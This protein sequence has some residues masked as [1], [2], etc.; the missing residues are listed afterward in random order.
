LSRFISFLHLL[1]IAAANPLAVVRSVRSWQL[2]NVILFLFRN[3]GNI[4]N[5]LRRA[6]QL[7]HFR[8][9]GNDDLWGEVTQYLLSFY[10]LPGT[11]N[12]D[13]SE[14]PTDEEIERWMTGLQ[15][16]TKASRAEKSVPKI[17]IIIPV[18]NQIRFTLACLHSVFVHTDRDDYEVI[19]ADD[20][21]TD[22]TFKVFQQ[23]ISRVVCLRNERGLGFLR[24]CNFAAEK[25]RGQYLV[26]LNNDTIV[27]PG[28]LDE[29]IT[30]LEGDPS[31]GLV[32]SKLLLPDKLL[33]EAGGIVF[34][35]GGAWN[36]GAFCD[37]GAPQFSYLRDVDYCSGASLAISVS[38]W[39]RLG[40]FDERFAP[41]YYEDTD[42]AFQVRASGKRVVYQPFSRLIHFGGVSNGKSPESGIKKF[43]KINQDKFYSKWRNALE[44]HGA[45]HPESL[46]ADRSDRGRVLFIDALIT[47]PDSDS[48]SMDA[49]NYMKIMK[50]LGFHVTFVPLDI[51]HYEKYNKILQRA[52]IES[53]YLP[54]V[55]SAKQAIKIYGPGSDIIILCRISVASSLLDYARRHAPQAKIIFDTV[56]LHFLR[57][58]REKELLGGS[59][60]ARAAGDTR[61]RE[62]RAI[63]KSDATLLRSTY[64]IELVRG[65]VPEAQLFHF[66]IVRD[67][68]GVSDILWEERRDIVFIGGFI[69]P[70]NIDAVKYFVSEV[71]PLL[72]AT[73]FQGRFVIIG[74]NVPEEIKAMAADDIVIRGFVEDLS[75]IFNRC[76]L[77]VAPIRYGAG[78]KGKVITSLSYGVPCVATPAAVEGSGLVHDE[79]VVVA[80]NAEEMAEMIQRLYGDQHLWNRL[81]QAGLAFCE[82]HFSLRV[83]RNIIDRALTDVLKKGHDDNVSFM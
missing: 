39:R 55:T 35:D 54:W 32:G 52:G 53:L 50:E 76:R 26:F 38:L 36:Y 83:A 12:E 5:I 69:H 13:V 11:F 72:R 61:K 25:S 45:C 41:A 58:E 63:K 75:D 60:M 34:E 67:I 79:H 30:T 70:P 6:K 17:S 82:D 62:I 8:Q 22:Q 40:G 14:L 29:L 9:W 7:Q 23:N 65:L 46:P 81:S 47:K 15:L 18:H 3:R 49:F 68:P 33:Q 31:V 20:N 24:N 80:E 10:G 43:Q 66:P 57:E 37:P 1:R 2:N 78:V 4:E 19:I 48:G 71:W 51:L 56:D 44:S 64:E 59:L 73:N 74:S 27:L 77:S 21:S 16:L 42:L 28:W